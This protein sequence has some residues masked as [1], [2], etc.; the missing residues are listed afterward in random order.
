LLTNCAFV[1]SLYS[2]NSL[3]YIL[4]LALNNSPLVFTETVQ[5]RYIFHAL[6]P[7]VLAISYVT[8]LLLYCRLF[9]CFTVRTSD[10]NMLVAIMAKQD[11]PPGY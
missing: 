5:T 10:E 3:L 6:F 7:V 4:V 1:G 2:M 8:C 11:P 9:Y